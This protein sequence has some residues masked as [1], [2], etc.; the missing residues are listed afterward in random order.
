LTVSDPDTAV[1]LGKHGR[2]KKGKEKPDDISFSYGT[3]ATCLLARLDRDRPDLAKR[4][5]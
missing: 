5:R 3:S 4:V 2:P 1:I